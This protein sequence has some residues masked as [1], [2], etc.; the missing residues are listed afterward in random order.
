MCQHVGLCVFASNH[1][2]L[3]RVTWV[4]VELCGF[5]SK[6]DLLKCTLLTKCTLFVKIIKEILIKSVFP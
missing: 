1:V 6:Q 3:R 5:T 2:S 4:Y